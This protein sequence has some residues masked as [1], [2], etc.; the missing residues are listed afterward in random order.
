MIKNMKKTIVIKIGSSVLLTKRNRL[1]EFRIAHI[2]EQILT[3]KDKNVGIVLVVSGAVACGSKFIDLKENKKLLKQAAAGIGQAELTSVFYGIFKQKDLQIAQ[4]LLTKNNLGSINLCSVLHWYI[5]TGFIP[6]IN[7]NDV[8]DLNSFEGNDF[9]GGKITTL[10]GSEKLIMLSTLEGSSFGIGGGKAKQQVI[11][12]L[13]QKNIQ[14]TIV[15]GKIK[16]IL[17]Q[18]LI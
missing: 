18:T 14:T 11:R 8:V 2:A 1:D 15:D 13:K 10:L 9:L 12:T 4:I 5:E 3:L 7:E 6:L 16:N 17:L